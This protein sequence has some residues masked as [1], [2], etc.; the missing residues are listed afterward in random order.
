MQNKIN[1]VFTVYAVPKS[2]KS[3]GI[4]KVEVTKLYDE[5]LKGLNPDIFPP[6]KAKI[7]CLRVA[8]WRK[9]NDL[10]AG[11]FEKGLEEAKLLQKGGAT[12]RD[13][14]DNNQ[15]WDDTKQR[16]KRGALDVRQIAPADIT[17]PLTGFRTRQEYRTLSLDQ[18]N[19][20]HA[21]LNQVYQVV[22]SFFT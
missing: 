16:K 14:R 12:T 13:P 1:N 11:D 19:R 4:V 15:P 17:R 3:G 5:C 10:K 7:W 9:Q 20:L 8:L 2:G 21:A 6:V 18:R 22:L